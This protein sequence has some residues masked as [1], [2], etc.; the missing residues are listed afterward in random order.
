M[1]DG[2]ENKAKV[3]KYQIKMVQSV[4]P[5][6]L[7]SG[8][9]S[10]TVACT[11]EGLTRGVSA[12]GHERTDQTFCSNFLPRRSGAFIPRRVRGTNQRLI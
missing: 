10:A 7:V 12:F 9:P 11:L 5:D 2:L 1:G 4:E 3:K 8:Y 6:L